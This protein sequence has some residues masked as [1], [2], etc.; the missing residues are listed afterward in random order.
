ME[1]LITLYCEKC[2]TSFPRRKTEHTRNLKKKRK[3]YC[4]RK[5]TG[6][7]NNIP[8]EKRLN[9]QH[10]KASN[11]TD[12][13]S[14]FRW[15]YHN[16]KRRGKEFDLDLPYLKKLWEEQEGICPYTG[17][18]LKNMTNSS[19]RHQLPMTP[20]RASLDRKDSKNGYLKGNVH[21]VSAMAQFC[22]YMWGDEELFSF[23]EAVYLK[24]ERIVFDNSRLSSLLERIQM[25]NV[26]AD[27]GVNSFT[28]MISDDRNKHERS[29]GYGHEHLDPNKPNPDASP[30]PNWPW[31]MTPG[32]GQK[33]PA[34]Q[35]TRSP[36]TEPTPVEEKK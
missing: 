27:N 12:E 8:P 31:P 18:K 10:L 11:R 22:K 5:C 26:T 36:V 16:S 7:I 32:H 9:T 17:W 35:T 20:D 13:Y 6:D 19:F 15:H 30:P 24:R 29:N 4:S 28:T 33:S 21:Y 25:E 14:P 2:G 1:T 23:A 34:P 3:I